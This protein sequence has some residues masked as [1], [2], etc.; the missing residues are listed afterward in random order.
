M[1]NDF[2]SCSGKASS[3]ISDN[4]VEAHPLWEYPAV[5]LSRPFE[6]AH[7][8]LTTDLMENHVTTSSGKVQFDVQGS[9]NGI[10]IWL[11]WILDLESVISTGPTSDVV[12]GKRISWD[13]HTRQGVFLFRNITD[14]NET[15]MLHWSFSHRAEETWKC[16][17]DFD[18]DS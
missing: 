10:A 17:F 8:D 11:D 13:F 5:A 15:K 2:F 9:C 16:E 3:E 18:I 6:L 12:P 1:L 14:V 4:P 7:F